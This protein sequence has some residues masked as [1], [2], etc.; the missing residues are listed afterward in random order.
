MRVCECV[1]EKKQ[2]E[3]KVYLL[4][5]DCLRAPLQILMITIY[6]IRNCCAAA[7]GMARNHEWQMEN[8]AHA[9]PITRRRM[10]RNGRAAGLCDTSSA[11]GAD[12]P[13]PINISNNNFIFDSSF[14]FESLISVFPLRPRARLSRSAYSQS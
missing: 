1:R 8:S 6:S 5:A 9:R 3:A 7:A 12:N 14:L 4:F 10:R 2:M 13:L 11:D